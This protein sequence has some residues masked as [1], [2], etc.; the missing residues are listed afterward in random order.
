MV[1][2]YNFYLSVTL[3]EHNC[4]GRCFA[5]FQSKST[6]VSCIVAMLIGAIDVLSGG[7]QT[8]FLMSELTGGTSKFIM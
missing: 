7:L 2:L 5:R 6:E 8:Y 4:F 3:P 1:N